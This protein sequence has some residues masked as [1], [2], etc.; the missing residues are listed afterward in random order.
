ML[1]WS[2][3]GLAVSCLLFGM[4]RREQTRIARMRLPD[5]KVTLG[6]PKK[7]KPR[8]STATGNAN[9]RTRAVPSC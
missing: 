3:C 8:I 4:A 2:D 5:E 9:S 7:D 1:C 6:R